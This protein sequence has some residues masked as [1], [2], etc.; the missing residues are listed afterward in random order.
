MSKEMNDSEFVPPI[1]PLQPVCE[2]ETSQGGPGAA[3]VTDNA[4][5][6]AGQ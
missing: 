3:R 4:G 2:S 6:W 5:Q 1:G